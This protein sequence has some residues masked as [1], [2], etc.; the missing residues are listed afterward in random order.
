V[1]QRGWLER[2]QRKIQE[3]PVL[4]IQDIGYF[5]KIT[6]ELYPRL[7]EFVNPWSHRDII[8]KLTSSY[9]LAAKYIIFTGHV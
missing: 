2:Q 3:K 9:F 8:P 6:L 7:F 1:R 5:I 4:R